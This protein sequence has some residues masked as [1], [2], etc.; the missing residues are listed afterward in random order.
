[1]LVNKNMS[2]KRKRDYLNT[3]DLSLLR[4]YRLYANKNYYSVLF[5]KNSK[6]ISDLWN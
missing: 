4:T 2:V 5:Q 3:V 1:M 6:T